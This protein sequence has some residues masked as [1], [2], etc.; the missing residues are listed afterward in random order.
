MVPDFLANAGG[1]IMSY[2]E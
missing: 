1:V 2:L